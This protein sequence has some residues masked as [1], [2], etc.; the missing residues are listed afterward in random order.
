MNPS[1]LQIVERADALYTNRSE[2]EN[3][4]E[5]VKLLSDSA[6]ESYEITWRLGRAHFFLGQESRNPDEARAHYAI[7]INS[8]RRAVKLRPDSVEGH[9]WLGVNLALMAHSKFKVPATFVVLR[10]KRSLRLAASIDP[11]YHA[12]GPL[13]VLARVQHKL[14]RIL[15]GGNERARTN[16]ERALQL[17]PNNTVTRIYFA[18]MLLEIGESAQAREQLDAIANVEPDPAWEFETRRD[19]KLARDK[20]VKLVN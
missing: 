18:E 9:F 11:G 2:I 19:R 15:G 10:A 4:R 6:M 20:L 17:A 13:R 14:P 1:L 5:S 3:V 8:S 16:F 7:G 12:A